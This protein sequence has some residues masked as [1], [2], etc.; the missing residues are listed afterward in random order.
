MPIPFTCPHCGLETTVADQ[1][2]GQTGPC[3][4]C[5]KPITVPGT[6]T[7]PGM[8][9]SPP[10]K[11]ASKAPIWIIVLAVALVVALGCGG[12]LLALLLPAVQSAHEAARRATCIN[13]LKQIGLAMH[14]Y[15]DMHGRLPPAVS[16]DNLGKPMMSWRVAILPV[17]E[18]TALYNQYDPKQPWDSPQNLALGKT[19]LQ[20]FR[21]PSDPGA[22]A[23][24]T[25]TNYVM[26]VGKDTVGG[27]PNEK[28]TF[29]DITDGT[30]KTIMVVEVSGLGI[31]WE[32]P[33]DLTVDEFMKMVAEGRASHHPGGFN[34][35]MVDGSVHFIKNTIDPATLRALLLRNDGQ[36]VGNYE[37]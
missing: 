22:A 17:L 7:A 4:R 35:L 13:K 1:Y 33:R 19:P 14:N 36:P 11:P 9:F 32:E 27:T 30:S 12:I 37:E 34:A 23:N 18:E 26:I 3:S 5:G 15:H 29:S 20:E 21:C 2:A 6:P 28:V 16:T 24:S 31:N 8:P 10:P 25:E